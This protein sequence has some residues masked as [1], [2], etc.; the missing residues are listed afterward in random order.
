MITT[1]GTRLPIYKSP[2]LGTS[3]VCRR[4][5]QLSKN[6]MSSGFFPI[7]TSIYNGFPARHLG[8]IA[9]FWGENLQWS[10]KPTGLPRR[11]RGDGH[12]W[13]L[14][15]LGLGWDFNRS[16]IVPYS[17]FDRSIMI[18][19]YWEEQ[20]RNRQFLSAP[21]DELGEPLAGSVGDILESF[22]KSTSCQ[23]PTNPALQQQ[24]AGEPGISGSCWMEI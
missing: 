24:W 22:F 9:P 1:C 18:Y 7:R 13:W 17:Y 14:R 6:L 20:W 5:S 4:R 3:T 15:A 2:F 12:G 10:P 16:I 21:S 19:H 23:R 11:P 8:N